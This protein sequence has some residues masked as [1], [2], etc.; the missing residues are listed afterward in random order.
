M[1]IPTPKSS[2]F[3][4]IFRMKNGL[5]SFLLSLLLAWTAGCFSV[6]SVPLRPRAQDQ[7]QLHASGGVPAEHFVIA[8]NG[9]YLFN[10][11]PLICG[12]ARTDAFFSW[13]LFSNEVDLDRLHNR[14]TRYAAQKGYLV[15]ELNVF[16][17]EEVLISIP[18]T[19]IPIPIPYVLTYREMQLSCVFTRPF[20]GDRK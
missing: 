20:S 8:N 4:I 14:L 12:N 11:L 2:R 1:I 13:R 5:S 9:W 7:I 3:G 18:G 16:N 10:A 15:E 17:S 6:E 19:S